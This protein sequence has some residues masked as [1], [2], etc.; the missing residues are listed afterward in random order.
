MDETELIK[1]KDRAWERLQQF[2]G[3]H[4]VGISTKVIGGQRTDEPTIVVY[5][6]QK[7]EL[8]DLNPEEV[9]PLEVDG[10]KTDVVQMR[11]P[12]LMA[13]PN[14]SVNVQPVGAPGAGAKI[15]LTSDVDPPPVGCVIVVCIAFAQIGSGTSTRLFTSAVTNGKISLENLAATLSMAFNNADDPI[16]AGTASP[17]AALSIS[18]TPGHTVV[19]SAYVLNFDT[20]KY[21]NEYVRGGIK[22]KAA[23][24][25]DGTLG[26]L[27]TTSPTAEDPQ[28]KVVAITN[29]H[30]VS[31]TEVY[32]TS[33]GIQVDK[34]DRNSL[35]A[36]AHTVEPIREHSIV[37][38]A[39]FKGLKI[40]GHVLYVT[41]KG[42]TL[43]S[44]AL[45]LT[46]AINGAAIPG[47]TATHSNLD[48][49]R[50]LIARTDGPNAYAQV[51][52]GGPPVLQP[53]RKLS[54]IIENPAPT[55][56]VLSFGG[57]VPQE[58]HG[59]FT[60]IDA[61]GT[62]P[63]FGTF[64]SLKKGQTMTAIAEAVAKSINDLDVEKVR[65]SVSATV[66]GDKVTISNAERVQC[67]IHSDVQVGQPDDSFGSP[68][69]RCCSHRIG[70]VIDA[71][72]HVDA[73]VIQ[74]DAGL[75]YKRQIEDVPSLAG[76][77]PAALNL[78][79]Q[80]RGFMSGLTFG[81]IQ[82]TGVNGSVLTGRQGIARYYENALVIEST[83]LDAGGLT[84]RPFLMKG[85]SGSAVTTTGTSPVKFVGL[86]FAGGDDTQ[87]LAMPIDQVIS[88]FPK[89]KLSFELV[90]GQDPNAVQTVPKPAI[91]FQGIETE[92]PVAVAPG[93][94][95]RTPVAALEGR[96]AEVEKE[97]VATAIGREYADAVRRHFAEAQTLFAHNKRV[98]TVWRRTGGPEIVNMIL[99]VLQFRD[100]RLPDEVDGRPLAEALSEIQRVLTRY[101]S[102][103]LSA[104]I[105]RYAP[106]LTRFVGMTYA[107]LLLTLQSPTE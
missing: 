39:F 52:T 21:F 3:V 77:A 53:G 74:L 62:R 97:I 61:T 49:T 70:R 65:G 44:V 92:T 18:P 94:R 67:F 5:V 24:G 99:R 103:H 35:R 107:E 72:L 83:M 60:H 68:C 37:F 96:L 31:F 47:V 88:A 16:D 58:H 45:A 101:A 102:P 64:V 95:T 1:I 27:A 59:V 55:T 71:Q 26:C 7:K 106:T 84:R 93:I 98:A 23:N 85:D 14:V 104:D 9:I 105:T 15:I 22:I 73:A 43:A 76:T 42:D 30:V 54:A 75:K 63:T 86:L 6:V 57:E 81:E 100:E 82:A 78:K 20:K 13:G 79:V 80:K 87:G 11:M 36:I 91:A 90:A 19:V 38:L 66:A 40:K 28:G 29:Q 56:T 46:G 12:R 41:Q 33:L 32:T 25:E 10:V 8:N 17:G 51:I 2:P 34:D 50:V 89:L 69:S 48:L 4:A